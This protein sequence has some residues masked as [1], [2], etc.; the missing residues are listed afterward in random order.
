MLLAGI[1]LGVAT[2]L[3]ELS[4]YAKVKRLQTLIHKYEW[5]GIVLSCTLALVLGHVFGAL[6]VTVMIGGVLSM[7]LTQPVYLYIN[8]GRTL[9]QQRRK[10]LIAWITAKPSTALTSCS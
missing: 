8:R 4:I 10:E 9:I 1:I 2:A 7:I 6:G 5:T 3:L